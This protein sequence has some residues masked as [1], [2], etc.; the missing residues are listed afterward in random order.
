MLVIAEDTTSDVNYQNILEDNPWILPVEFLRCTSEQ[1]AQAACARSNADYLMFLCVGDEL[2]PGAVEL[3]LTGVAGSGQLSCYGACRW[4]KNTDSWSHSTVDQFFELA[5]ITNTT[6]TLQSNILDN[7]SLGLFHRSIFQNNADPTPQQAATL[8][9]Y[10]CIRQNSGE[11]SY[12]PAY[13]YPRPIYQKPLFPAQMPG[14]E[15]TK[16]SESTKRAVWL[17]SERAGESAE[18]NAWALFKHCVDSCAD[19]ESY[20][21]LKHK[22]T[23]SPEPRYKSRIIYKGSPEW[24]K[25]IKQASH[26]FFTDTA[27]D[28]LVSSLDALNYSNTTF[29]YL[30]H[31]YLAYSP[32]VYQRRLPYINRVICSSR[33]DID[34]ASRFWGFSKSLFM[35]TGLPRWDTL[36]DTSAG[37]NEILILPTWRKTFDSS[38]WDTS[39]ALTEENVLEFKSSAYFQHFNGLLESTELNKL[40]LRYNAQITFKLHFR[41]EKYLPLFKQAANSNIRISTQETDSRDIKIL[42]QDA[43]LLITDYSSVM[44]DMGQMEKP[45]ICYQFDKAA[46]LGERKID[47]FALADNRIF[48]DMCSTQDAVLQKLEEYLLADFTIPDEKLRLLDITLPFRDRENCKRIVEKIKHSQ[49]KS[50]QSMAK[51]DEQF[52]QPSLA[53]YLKRLNSAEIDVPANIGYLLN[54]PDSKST[55]HIAIS[56]DNWEDIIKVGEIDILLL[57]PHLNAQSP[58]ATVFFSLE[59]LLG[60]LQKISAFAQQHGVVS[61]LFEPQHHPLFDNI[62][63]LRDRFD[64]YVP[65]PADLIIQS[66]YDISVII[67]A[68]NCADILSQCIDSVLKQS[69][70]GSVELVIVDDG[71]TDTTWDVITGYS[72]LYSNIQVISQANAKQGVARDRG[73]DAARGQYVTFVDADDVLPK[74]CLADLHHEIRLTSADISV[75]L[76]ASTDEKGNTQQINQAY[77]H[78]SK[79]PRSFT[80]ASWPHVF[81]DPSC[82]GKLI[83]RRLLLEHKIYFPQSYHEDQ[84]FNFKLFTSA[85]TICKT[86]AVVYLYIARPAASPAL[87]G[88]QTFTA[89]KFRQILIAAQLARSILDT[90]GLPRRVKNHALGFLILRYDRFLWKQQSTTTLKEAPGSQQQALALLAAFLQSVPDETIWNQAKHLPLALLLLKRQQF[91]LVSQVLEGNNSESFEYLCREG[92]IPVNILGILKSGDQLSTRYNYYKAMPLLSA[93]SSI[94]TQMDYGYRLGSVFV[95]IAKQPTLIFLLPFRLLLLVFDMLSKRGRKKQQHFK[96]K[97]AQTYSH[98]QFIERSIILKKTAAHQLGVAILEAFSKS[99]S[100]I[101]ELPGRIKQ[102]YVQTR[103]L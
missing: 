72:Q 78:Y 24:N 49:G 66:T 91:P 1:L 8:K 26:M 55:T 94:I 39:E 15:S 45:V 23:I 36:T 87:S 82:V 74:N 100:K 95:D 88:T 77:Y 14:E 18:D 3:L 90:S 96:N 62:L 25:R 71:S 20:Y 46:M 83:S 35:Q 80:P 34:A 60:F 2:L 64:H 63:P 7:G 65:L 54:I 73:L 70:T 4:S 92:S 10:V 75:G 98:Q 38:R 27:A 5:A 48:T 67:P 81:Y 57:E 102:I 37:R 30:T 50:E 101:F 84:V 28:I 42:L 53:S 97:M 11:I 19:I 16:R 32:G 51:P 12:T 31:G 52:K 93:N 79:A 89:E 76:V 69:Y 43:S 29:I 59:K 33:L 47:A 44:F 9:D 58:W 41:L 40:L 86:N 21:V 17:F 85:T 6:D 99:P 61:V 13:P 22:K 56:P 68:Y 103:S